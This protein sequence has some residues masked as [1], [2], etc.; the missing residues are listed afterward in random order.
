M[1][2]CLQAANY[3]TERSSDLPD[4]GEPQHYIPT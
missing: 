3:R 4:S 2:D 1:I